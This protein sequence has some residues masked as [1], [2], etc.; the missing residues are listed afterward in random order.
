MGR[1][2]LKQGWREVKMGTYTRA[3][4][5]SRH[6]TSCQY[7][8][9]AEPSWKPEGNRAHCFSP[10]RVASPPTHSKK[11]NE[12]IKWIHRVKGRMN[13]QHQLPIL[14]IFR[15]ASGVFKIKKTF[16]QKT[17]HLVY[18]FFCALFIT[19]QHNERVELTVYNYKM[20]STFLKMED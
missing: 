9:Q 7:P 16:G 17:V 5:Y 10:C 8:P 1:I 3:S 13:I 19:N 14:N 6:L 20:V 4:S 18:H 12:S 2:I 15:V 11:G